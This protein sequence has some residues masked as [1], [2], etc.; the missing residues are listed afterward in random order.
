MRLFTQVA[1]GGAKRPNELSLLG[2]FRMRRRNE[3]PIQRARFVHRVLAADATVGAEPRG[4]QVC[5][6]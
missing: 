1:L 5:L 6:F 2:M 3:V 4:T